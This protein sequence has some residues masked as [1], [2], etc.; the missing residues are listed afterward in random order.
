MKKR[1]REPKPTK[2]PK[3]VEP[4]QLEHVQGGHGGNGTGLGKD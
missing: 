4:N 1:T 3:L 2:T